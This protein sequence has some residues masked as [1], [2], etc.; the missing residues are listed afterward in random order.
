VDWTTFWLLWIQTST[1][2]MI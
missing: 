2:C 1:H